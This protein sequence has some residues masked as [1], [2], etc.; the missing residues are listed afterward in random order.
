MHDR[1][2]EMEPVQKCAGFFDRKTFVFMVK[3][4]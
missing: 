3:C 2:V 1:V 4:L